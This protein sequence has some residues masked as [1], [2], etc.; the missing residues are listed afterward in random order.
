MQP[1][2]DRSQFIG[3]SDIAAILG[4]SRY[5]TPL[6]VWAEKTGQVDRIEGPKPMRMRVGTKMED[7]I[8]ELWMEETGKTLNRVTERRVHPKYPHFRAQIDRIVIGEDAT[9]EGKNTNWRL[10]KD[11]GDGEAPQEAICQAMWGLAVT[12][13]KC[14][15]IAG[16]IDS[17]E[18]KWIKLDRDPIMI[19][20][21]L[22]RANFFWDNFVAPKIMPGPMTA[23]D[24]DALYSLFPNSEPNSEMELSDDV[25]KIIETRNALYQ[26]QIA[27]EQQI[28]QAENEIKARMGTT[29]AAKAGKWLVTWKSQISKRLDTALFKNNEPDLY[30][31]YSKESPSRVFRIK[32]TKN[33]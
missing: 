24:G 21:M 15:Y 10:K 23:K 12:G 3:G 14:T 26:D 18:L 27:L 11:W 33:G 25:A 1:E 13:K 2:V 32:E 9:W 20:E 4:L 29:E 22:K 5:Q 17:A 19:A 16:L 8:A 28:E 7:V 31:K 30:K 6:G